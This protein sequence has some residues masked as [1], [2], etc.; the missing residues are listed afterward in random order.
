M[1][2]TQS[3]RV[4]SNF[5]S[6][7]IINVFVYLLLWYEPSFGWK[8]KGSLPL[9]LLLL[10]NGPQPKATRCYLS[11]CPY[12][13]FHPPRINQSI[14]HP[15]LVLPSQAPSLPSTFTLCFSASFPS[16]HPSADPG[17]HTGPS[18]P[19]PFLSLLL[20]RSFFVDRNPRTTSHSPFPCSFPLFLHHFLAASWDQLSLT[21]FLS[22]P[23]RPLPD[24]NQDERQQ[25][26]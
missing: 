1:P 19:H 21:S 12:P 9:L 2:A 20:Q 18:K 16:S 24:T 26:I 14:S 23:V 11:P 4:S 10:N 7:V 5:S 22:Y 17:K 8:L 3:L 13:S 6:T 15:E 25:E